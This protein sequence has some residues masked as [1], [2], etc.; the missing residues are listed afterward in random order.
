MVNLSWTPSLLCHRLSLHNARGRRGCET[1]SNFKLW[2]GR[3]DN[4][5][6][7]YLWFVCSA[8]TWRKERR[9][10]IWI[11]THYLTSAASSGQSG[12]VCWLTFSTSMPPP[13]A[14]TANLPA[15][16]T[17]WHFVTTILNSSHNTICHQ[18]PQLMT[19]IRATLSVL[20]SLSF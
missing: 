16:N 5:W 7:L 19:L 20:I 4:H 2:T 12:S 15:A 9:L 10:E 13:L 17:G 11:S 14:W 18:V 6:R 3:L 8:D 1:C